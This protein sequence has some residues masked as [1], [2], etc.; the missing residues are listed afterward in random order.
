MKRSILALAAVS[1]ALGG[2]SAVS[3]VSTAANTTATSS[4]ISDARATVYG[5]ESLYG[6]SL[7]VAVSWASQPTCGPNAPSAPLCSTPAGIVAV[8]KAQLAVSAALKSAENLVQSASPGAS[9]LSLAVSG[10]Q[11]A[12]S[13]YTN[14]LAVYGVKTSS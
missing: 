8:A 13:A 2:C 10:L 9:D 6:A 11:A 1:F 7:A 5:L 4:Q 12:Y 14:A 3:A